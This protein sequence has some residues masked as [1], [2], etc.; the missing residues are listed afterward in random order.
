MTNMATWVI[1]DIADRFPHEALPITVLDEQSLRRL[2]SHFASK[3]PRGL[4]VAVSDDETV[5][6]GIGGP[7]AFL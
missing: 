2:L 7:W 5:E 4:S 3:G 1:Q 6:V